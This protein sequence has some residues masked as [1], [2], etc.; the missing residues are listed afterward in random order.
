MDELL[1][2]ELQ[3]KV[4][5]NKNSITGDYLSGKKFIPVPAKRRKGNGL[6]LEIIGAKANNLKK[7]KCKN[8]TSY[9]SCVT[10][11]SGSGKSSLVNEVLRKAL[12]R[13]LNRNHAKPGEHKEIK[14]IET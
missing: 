1:Q 10:G 7:R 9:F 6:E 13:K 11:V 3:K 12:A 5:K 4:A 2:P 8:S 14:G